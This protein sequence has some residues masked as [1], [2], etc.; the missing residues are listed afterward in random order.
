MTVTI[1]PAAAVTAGARWWIDS[2]ASQ[3]S[4]TTLSGLSVGTHTLSFSTLPTWTTPTK[5]T[6]TITNG[7]TTTATGIYVAPAQTGSLTVTLS[8]ASAVTAGAR[9]WIDNGASQSSGTTLSGLSPGSHTLSFSSVS[10]WTSPAKRAITIAAGAN[11][12]TGTYVQ[13]T[14]S[15]TVNITP[16]EAVTAGARWWIDSGASQSSGTTLSGLSVGTHT[17]SFSTLPT[18]TTPAKTTI[19]I[20]NGGTTT[21]SGTYVVPTQTGSLT[22]TLSPASAVTAGARWWIDN[23]ASQSGG[24]TLS[25]LSPGSHTLSFSS[26]SGWTAPVKQAITIATGANTATSTYVQQTGSVTVNIT[27]AEAVTAGARWWIDSGAS[28]S[29]GTTLSGLSV[30]THTLTFST[31]PTWTTPVKTTITITNGGTTAAT[32]TYVV[33]AQTGSLTVTLSPAAAVTAG[34]RW[35]IDNGA[36]QSSGA[37]LSRPQPRHAHPVILLRLRLDRSCKESHYH[38]NRRQQCH[39]HL[40]PVAGFAFTSATGVA[41]F[42][43]VLDP[44]REMV[45]KGHFTG[46]HTL[47]IRDLSSN[48]S[49]GRSPAKP[50][51]QSP[52][53]TAEGN[54]AAPG[55]EPPNAATPRTAIFHYIPGP[56][57]LQSALA[58]KNSLIISGM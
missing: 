5:T 39:G 20:T 36:S 34:A 33:P 4:G 25:G 31:L 23:G 58:Y 52:A 10:G 57:G 55:I 45:G 9:W 56:G 6:I 22:V 18:W 38:H 32:G 54:A 7:G 8:P 1:T 46:R 41:C 16:A 29:S 50:S 44:V 40:H 28:Q 47:K 13:Q 2:D 35:W 21:A 30:G 37:T 17:L 27:P 26:V 24:A 43:R 15:L 14:G 42:H 48:F 49:A 51:Q 19:T 11:T 12:A 53:I 3:S